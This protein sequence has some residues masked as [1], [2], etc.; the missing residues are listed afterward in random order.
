MKNLWLCEYKLMRRYQ[1]EDIPIKKVGLVW[2]ED[3]DTALK[4]VAESHGA[5]SEVAYYR[6]DY[7]YDF[8]AT[9]AIGS[10]F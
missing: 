7:V 5:K 2:A 6:E 9:A 3:E 1:T 8:E 4:T 10:P